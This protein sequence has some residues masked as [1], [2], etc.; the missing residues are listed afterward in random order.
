MTGFT[1]SQVLDAAADLI[2]PEGCWTQ[3]EWARDGDGRGACHPDDAAC[4]CGWGAI[5]VSSVGGGDTRALAHS[6]VQ[7]C[8][9]SIGWNDAPERTQAEVVAVLRK[10][11]ELARS[12]G[13]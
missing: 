1:P 8:G 9:F 6:F 13:Q 3:R 10:A 2:E 5:E 7:R 4:W 11:A 12:E